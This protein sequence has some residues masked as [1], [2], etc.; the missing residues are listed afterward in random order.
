MALNAG[1]PVPFGVT[2]PLV[3]NG[4]VQFDIFFNYQSNQWSLIQDGVTKAYGPLA[5]NDVSTIPAA[6]LIKMIETIL[7]LATG[8]APTPPAP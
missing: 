7:Y 1:T 3:Y 4:T 2:Y 6:D 5:V 8:V